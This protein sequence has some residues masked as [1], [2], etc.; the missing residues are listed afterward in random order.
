[1][2]QVFSMLPIVSS[3]PL[4]L[5]K[6]TQKIDSTNKIT[7]YN[8]QRFA[9]NIFEKSFIIQKDDVL[10][11]LNNKKLLTD[12]KNI[13]EIK[14]SRSLYNFANR[15]NYNPKTLPSC[16][17]P[18][19]KPQDIDKK[20]LVIDLDETLVYSTDSPQ[21]DNDCFVVSFEHEGKQH[22]KYVSK[23]PHVDEFL[24][25]MG[26]L[27]ECV[28]FTSAVPEYAELVAK[29]IDKWGVFRAV[30]SRK[31][32]VYNGDYIKDLSKLGRTLEKT[33]I[34]DDIKTRY[35]F[36]PDNAVP[37][38][39]WFGGACKKEELNDTTLSDLIPFF[40]KLSTEKNV[41]TV[42]TNMDHP[43]HQLLPDNVKEKWLNER[44][45]M[46]WYKRFAKS[47]FGLQFILAFF[48]Y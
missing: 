17:L 9:S 34:I 27:Y 14:L 35:K 4:K 40:E 20:C 7:F 33:I 47:F 31:S 3:K 48:I 24:Q 18:P 13:K 6:F 23:R 39:G 45:S 8:S 19:V 11:H 43:Y 16:L 22:K 42:L 32:C 38:P 37:V 10:G 30:L 12:I 2:F 25:A 5:N 15:R 1:M 21:E 36:Q 46:A 28:L 26:Q 44:K 29:H 41:Y